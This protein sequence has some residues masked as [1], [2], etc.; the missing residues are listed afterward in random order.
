MEIGDEVIFINNKNL[1]ELEDVNWSKE[2]YCNLFI[3]EKYII[4]D[5]CVHEDGEE[6]IRLECIR[7][8]HPMKRF[9]LVEK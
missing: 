5:I 1:D 3:N 9:K 6:S 8:W 7:Y 4:E 2:N